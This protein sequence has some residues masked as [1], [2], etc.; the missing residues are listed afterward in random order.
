MDKS[1]YRFQVG[2]IACIALL[3]GVAEDPVDILMENVDL[4]IVEPEL[5]KYG[6]KRGGNFS[7]PFTCLLINTG[8]Q[9]VLIDTGFGDIW[10]SCGKLADRLAEAG[11]KPVDIDIVILSH[12]HGDHIGG[13]VDKDGKIQFPNARWVMAKDEWRFW[14][15]PKN[16]KDLPAFYADIIER[17]LLPISER[18][19]LVDGETEIVPGIFTIPLPGH[20]PG[21]LMI[22]VRSEGQELLYTADAMLHPLHLDHP[23]WCASHWADFDWDEVIHSRRKLYEWAAVEHSTVLAFHFDPFPSLGYIEQAGEGWKWLPANIPC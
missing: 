15:N 8:S 14:N 9:R 1:I 6:L 20:T 22:A 2:K 17:K 4:D 10:P 13:N 7:Y 11:V 12:A 23:D 19:E 21:H 18:I 3:D 5:A 16:L